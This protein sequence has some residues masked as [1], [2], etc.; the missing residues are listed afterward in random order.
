[1][2][3][4]VSRP[5]PRG[6]VENAPGCQSWDC[7]SAGVHG[8]TQ[9]ATEPGLESWASSAVPS[10]LFPIHATRLVRWKVFASEHARK[11]AWPLCLRAWP[12]SR[13]EAMRGSRRSTRAL[14]VFAR[15]QCPHKPKPSPWE[16]SIGSKND[17][18]SPQVQ[19]RCRIGSRD[20]GCLVP[21]KVPHPRRL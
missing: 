16:L 10:R 18:V 17:E 13:L 14:P 1:V 4:N 9:A 2:W 15:V 19:T 12:R 6:T 11:P 3:G 20:S 7:Q 8:R 21:G 5:A